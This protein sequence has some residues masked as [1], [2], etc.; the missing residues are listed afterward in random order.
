MGRIVVPLFLLVTQGVKF[1]LEIVC[2]NLR[3]QIKEPSL[4]LTSVVLHSESFWGMILFV[5]VKKHNFSKGDLG[6][7]RQQEMRCGDGLAGPISPTFENYS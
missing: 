1:G 6:I 4:A 5:N 2:L 3:G 7:A